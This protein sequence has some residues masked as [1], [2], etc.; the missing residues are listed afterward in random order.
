[1]IGLS[2]SAFHYR[3][4]PRSRVADPIA[5]RQRSHPAKLTEVEYTKVAD[6]LEDSEVSVTETFYQHLDAGDYV[7]SQSTFHRIANKEQIPMAATGASKRVS[8]QATTAKTP[9][10]SATRPGQ[11]MCWDISFL[12]GKYRGQHFA[13]YLIIDL[14]SRKILGFTI[15]DREDEIIAAELISAVIDDHAGHVQTVH[16]DNGAAMTANRMKRLLDQAG[17][18]QSFIRPGVSNDNAQIESLFRTVKYGPSWPGSFPDLDTATTWFTEFVEA[19]NE[20]HH[21]TSLAGFTASQVYEG[22]WLDAAIDRQA[23]LDTA[24]R[25]NPHRYRKPPVVKPPAQRV[26]LNLTNDNK[27]HTPPTLLELIAA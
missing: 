14:F 4:K 17:I 9:T 3:N 18:T 19:Y 2:K 12:P 21:H 16:S 10:L 7:A 11:V 5:H 20:E 15:Q 8:R 13:L 24:Y 1:M 25:A 6:L 26:T 22:S 23:T 27:T